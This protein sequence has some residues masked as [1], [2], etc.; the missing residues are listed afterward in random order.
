MGDSGIVVSSCVW[1]YRWWLVGEL[2]KFLTGLSDL[3]N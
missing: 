3:S 2:R 1:N